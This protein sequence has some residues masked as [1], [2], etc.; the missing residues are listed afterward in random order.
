MTDFARLLETEIPRLR[1]YARALTRDVTRADDLVQ[2]C[3]TRAVAKQHLWQPGTDLRAWLFTILHNQHVNDVRRSVREGVSVAVE[4]MAP[5]LTVQSN[6]Y[7]SLQL[8]DLETAI[9]KLP[10]EQ[11]QVILL[12]GL[13]GMRYEEVALILGVPVGTVRSRLSRGR[14]QLRRLM[15]MHDEMP[16]A[17]A[18]GEDGDVPPAPPRRPDHV[19]ARRDADAR[20]A[21]RAPERRYA[22]PERLVG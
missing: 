1:R 11:R 6:A 3:L 19:H 9:A 7:A 16:M 22:S 14:D 12:V 4:D 15:D 13:E 17:T 18:E 2:S 8:R 5:V 10:Q 20:R 21:R